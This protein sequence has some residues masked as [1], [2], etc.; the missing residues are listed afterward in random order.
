M[1]KPLQTRFSNKKIWIYRFLLGFLFFVGSIII[2]KPADLWGQTA[3]VIPDDALVYEGSISSLN[4]TKDTTSIIFDGATTFKV[5]LLFNN[6][7]VLTGSN[8]QVTIPALNYQSQMVETAAGIYGL[9]FSDQLNIAIQFPYVTLPQ[10]EQWQIEPLSYSLSLGD[11]TKIED[12]AVFVT[13]LSI[14]EE[15]A[16]TIV[17][18]KAVIGYL[19][20]ANL[21]LSTSASQDYQIDF[22]IDFQARLLDETQTPLTNQSFEATLEMPGHN[23]LETV[24]LTTDSEGIFKYARQESAIIKV[25]GGNYAILTEPLSIEGVS[26]AA[27]GVATV[28]G[29]V[30]ENG[31]P[32]FKAAVYIGNNPTVYSDETGRYS[33]EVVPGT[34]T[35]V[36]HTGSGE[37]IGEKTLTLGQ[38]EISA[39]DFNFTPWVITG[40]VTENGN[41]LAGARVWAGRNRPVLTDSSGAYSADVQ[42][43]EIKI[44]VFT[45][46][47]EFIG[48]RTV[49]KGTGGTAD[50]DF[51]PAVVKGIVTEKGSPLEG[52]KVYVGLNKPFLTNASGE[53]VV[54]AKSGF[55]RVFAYTGSDEFIGEQM[56]TLDEKGTAVVNFDFNPV[57]IIGTVTVDGLGISKADVY[58][59]ANVPVK[60]D[61]IGQY[62]T[63]VQVG[64]WKVFAENASNELIAE[65]TVQIVPQDIIVVNL[66]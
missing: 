61:A 47:G 8:V 45:A 20:H 65:T 33:A 29:V 9:S 50:F 31:I 46:M 2:H 19:G 57:N 60:T 56:V 44:S 43:D 62:L 6:Q 66:P 63:R 21:N 23:Y 17:N 24:S 25:T 30:S 22:V 39:A 53:Y 59:G 36:A 28:T 1:T 12:A 16:K 7:N 51:K 40:N 58:V 5:Y 15:I 3:L 11:Q 37:F 42:G 48:G 35:M 18:Q 14:V 41:A 27:E 49:I 32:I 34:T 10:I 13:P 4:V 55:A 54:R 52:A 26:F 64:T 38:G